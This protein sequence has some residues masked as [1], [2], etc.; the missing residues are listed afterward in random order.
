M[1]KPIAR[2]LIYRK[3]VFDADNIELCVRW[4]IRYRLSYRD[5]FEMMVERGLAAV[6]LTTAAPGKSTGNELSR[7]DDFFQNWSFAQSIPGCTR[8]IFT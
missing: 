1:T 3:H 6:G 4:H 2:D 5:L 8:T 7:S